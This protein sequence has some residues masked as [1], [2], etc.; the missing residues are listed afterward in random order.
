MGIIRYLLEL[1]KRS[2]YPPEMALAAANVSRVY[3]IYV[4]G[5]GRPNYTTYWDTWGGTYNNPQFPLAE[6]LFDLFLTNVSSMLILEGLLNSFFVQVG[7]IYVNLPKKPWQYL[8]ADT[9]YSE[10]EYYTSNVKDAENPSNITYED[11]AGNFIPVPVRMA[12]PKVELSLSDI[13]SDVVLSSS[14]SVSLVNNDGFFDAIQQSNYY[15]TPVKIKRTTIENPVLADFQTIRYG[16]VDY[17]RVSRD[18]FTI[19]ISDVFKSFSQEI[20][21]TITVTLFPTAPAASIDKPMP[22]G[23]GSF[24]APLINVGTNLWLAVDPAYL[25]S[26]SQ[27]Y[28]SSGTPVAFTVAGGVITAV[29]AAYADIVCLSTNRIGEIIINEITSKSNIA[30]TPTTWDTTEAD[31]YKNNSYRINL[32]FPKGNLKN[33]IAECLKSDMAFLITKNDGRLTLRSWG[34]SYDATTLSGWQ[35]MEFPE[36]D[37]Q[38]ATKLFSSSVN[39]YYGRNFYTNKYIYNYLDD[40]EENIL[41]AVYRKRKQSTYYTDLV[42]GSDAIALAGRILDRFKYV[43]ET[44]PIK[45]GVDTTDIN[46]LAD[47]TL[48]LIINGRT[49][50]GYTKWAVNSCDPGQDTLTLIAIS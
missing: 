16:F 9:E 43:F 48:P 45:L 30:Y 2:E 14:F 6:V 39:V 25:V 28:N 42:S 1:I 8:F 29:A 38:E 46:L 27:V 18:T 33:L 41:E 26:V 7:A 44:V 37:T 24:T 35:L 49:F 15:N 34:T 12:V 36:R 50:S 4:I 13:F 19:S 17:V 5:T 3:N 23:W 32:F 11:I 20:T 22:L 40:S 47:I 21:S 31:S 10:I